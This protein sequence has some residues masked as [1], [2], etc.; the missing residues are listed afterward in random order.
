MKDTKKGETGKKR[1]LSLVCI[2]KMWYTV[3]KS[4]KPR[5]RE[6]IPMKKILTAVA[7]SGALALALSASAFAADTLS[8]SDVPEDHWAYTAIADM[9]ERE[10]LKG[11]SPAVNGVGTFSPDD[12]MSRAAF[13]TV[14][15]RA[16]YPDE[17]KPAAAGQKWYE[18]YTAVARVH[19]IVRDGELADLDGA[20]LRQE[21]ATVL[22]RAAD[23]QRKALGEPASPSEIADYNTIERTY[24]Q[25]VSKCFGCGMIKGI[26]SKGTFAPLGKMNRAQAAAVV[27]RLLRM[28]S[29]T[30][31]HTFRANV[32]VPTAATRGYTEY[33]CECGY[34]YKDLYTER[35]TGGKDSGWIN[36]GGV[37]T[38]TDNATVTGGSAGQL[39]PDSTLVKW[40]LT[41]P[42]SRVNGGDW[43]TYN[44]FLF[45]AYGFYFVS[46]GIGQNAEDRGSFAKVTVL[47]DGGFEVNVFGWRKSDTSTGWVHSATNAGLNMVMEAFYYACGDREVAY[48]LWSVN[49]FLAI[50]G[51]A[52]TTVEKVESFGFTTSNETSD[53]IV[54]SMNGIDILWR[55]DS[56]NNWFTF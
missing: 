13:I 18:P 45:K 7:L 42:A 32:I 16:L 9:T 55:W 53:S 43:N 46:G 41:R 25:D 51:S 4:C 47:P 6:D 38:G 21:M 3:I 5:M 27:Y 37:A 26:D 10:L 54:L 20:M 52:A 40:K 28:E 33:V 30:S 2:P 22:V 19:G 8:F 24:Q 17:I 11:T 49:D 50:N 14:I 12:D 23:L 31:D 56:T 48:A 1:G 29:G 44:G 35:L 39:I 34:S 15:V 36:T